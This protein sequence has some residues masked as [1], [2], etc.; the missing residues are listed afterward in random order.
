MRVKLADH[1]AHGARRFFEFGR[2]LE[3]EFRHRVDDPALHRLQ[4]VADMRQ[5]AVEDDVHGII[6]I[7]LLGV[8]L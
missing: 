5:G 2:G 8:G 7:R 1:I 3:A 6:Q 4:A